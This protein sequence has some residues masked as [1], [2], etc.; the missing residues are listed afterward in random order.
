MEGLRLN[1]SSHFQLT[2]GSYHGIDGAVRYEPSASAGS[3][4]EVG[5]HV[6]NDTLVTLKDVNFSAECV[7]E[8]VGSHRLV[9]ILHLD[10]QRVIDVQN[11]DSFELTVP[12][13]VTC[14]EPP[15]T[16]KRHI[17]YEDSSY[18]SVSIGFQIDKPPKQ[19][20][21]ALSPSSSDL[22][23]DFIESGCFR[24]VKVPLSSDMIKAAKAL[25]APPVVSPLTA[26]YLLSKSS[27]LLYICLSRL[28]EQHSDEKRKDSVILRNVSAIDENIKENRGT[29]IDVQALCDR[30]KLRSGE[31][32]RLFVE[33][34]GMSS[35][36]Y[37]QRWRM[38]HAAQLLT[39]TDL[40]IKQIAYEVGH[41]HV[42][43][44]SISF[45]KHFNLTPKRAR[46]TG[47]NG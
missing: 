43:N 15:G 22:T 28:L 32:E 29:Q 31:F 27:E 3:G 26:P 13:F 18:S 46:L 6:G 8:E 5:F 14:Y 23:K 17:W 1:H 16:V 37:R 42:S 19:I 9:F 20:A 41:N 45:K 39:D 38:L 12:S 35:D 25:L 10:G 40:P 11:G 47:M 34:M 36:A 33:Q 4:Y 7:S 24:W 21:A 44:F 30:L 2:A